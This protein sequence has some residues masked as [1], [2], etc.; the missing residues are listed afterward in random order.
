MVDAQIDKMH[1]RKVAKREIHKAVQCVQYML[2]EKI[3]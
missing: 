3:H 2:T 1:D